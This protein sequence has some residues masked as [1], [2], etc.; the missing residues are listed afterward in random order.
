[1]NGSIAHFGCSQRRW[2]GIPVEDRDVQRRTRRETDMTY[3]DLLTTLTDTA[4]EVGELLLAAPRSAPAVTFDEL[5]AS[6]AESE[7]PGEAVVRRRLGALRPGAAWA[8]ELD[9]LAALPSDGEVWIVDVVDGAVQ[10]LQ[11]LPQFCVSLA[12]VCEGEPV[13]A[14]LH[15]PLLNET[16]TA[17]RGHGAARDGRPIV[18]SV[19]ADLAAAVLSTSQPPFVARQPEAAEQ[20]GRSL[21]AVLPHVAAVRNLGP[22]SWQIADTAAGRLDGFWEF[23]RDDTNLL[24]GVLVARE[25]GA[26]VT[27]AD[28]GPWRA[29]CDSFLVAGEALHKS[30]LGVLAGRD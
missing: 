9:S 12:L 15:A 21:S 4:H 8:E 3:Q 26:V 22:T 19:K 7:A 25:A 28:G 1:M 6:F 2:T 27:D 5:A 14:V 29:G 17:A 18:P 30:L 24:P 20:A 10:F 13:A 16:Y 23:G 11:G